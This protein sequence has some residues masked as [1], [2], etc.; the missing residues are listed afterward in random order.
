MSMAS[1]TLKGMMSSKTRVS[2]EMGMLYESKTRRIFL[3]GNYWV[4]SHHVLFCNQTRGATARQCWYQSS[5]IRRSESWM[6]NSPC[7]LK[8][9]L[10]NEMCEEEAFKSDVSPCAERNKKQQ[11]FICFFDV[12]VTSRDNF[13]RDIHAQGPQ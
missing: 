10:L 6:W 8:R 11:I 4:L 3:N 5:Q 1:Q 7:V 13:T 2:K 12:K 9:R